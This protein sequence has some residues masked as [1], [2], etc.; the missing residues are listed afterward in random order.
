MGC[1]NCYNMHI[2]EDCII[3]GSAFDGSTNTID[4]TS[5]S[6]GESSDNEVILTPDDHSYASLPTISE[7]EDMV[8]RPR[9]ISCTSMGFS[10]I[11]LPEWCSAH[12]LLYGH[13]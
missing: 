12:F 5:L 6:D 8:L 2:L 1:D 13:V 4:L 9:S 3:D 11:I 10:C 7:T